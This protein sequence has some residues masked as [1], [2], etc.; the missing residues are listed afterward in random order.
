[1]ID[2]MVGQDHP[3]NLLA[4]GVPFDGDFSVVS[5]VRDH[6]QGKPNGGVILNQVVCSGNYLGNRSVVRSYGV[7][8]KL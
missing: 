4:V 1:M 2:V 8:V 5:T 7:D 6:I 3:G